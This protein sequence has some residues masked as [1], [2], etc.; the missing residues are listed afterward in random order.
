MRNAFKLKL[1]PYSFVQVCKYCC[2]IKPTKEQ[3]LNKWEESHT[4]LIQQ[5]Q[6][7]IIACGQLPT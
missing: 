2:V 6:R 3:M 7:Y 4:D 5:N 1:N